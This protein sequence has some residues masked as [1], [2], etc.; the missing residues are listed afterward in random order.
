MCLFHSY[1]IAIIIIYILF[2][3]NENR[4]HPPPTPILFS[5]Q[6]HTRNY[7]TKLQLATF[8]GQGKNVTP[9]PTCNILWS[10]KE[11]VPLLNFPT[12]QLLR[13]STKTQFTA[14]DPWRTVFCNL[15]QKSWAG[16]LVLRASS[17]SLLGVVGHNAVQ[18][19]AGTETLAS[20]KCTSVYAKIVQVSY[21]S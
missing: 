18:Q 17:R 16:L 9:T 20:I 15:L 14:K 8:Y 21:L 11:N 2:L 6:T 7:K 4:L 19:G 12:S 3:M 10:R 5:S 1:T 13:S